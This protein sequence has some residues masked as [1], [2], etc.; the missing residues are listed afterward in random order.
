MMNKNCGKTMVSSINYTEFVT[1]RI[2]HL[3]IRIFR[4]C[5]ILEA[6]LLCSLLVLAFIFIQIKLK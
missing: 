4:Y 3:T 5:G 2:Y 6:A 1:V